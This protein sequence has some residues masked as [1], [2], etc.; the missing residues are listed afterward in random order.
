MIQIPVDIIMKFTRRS[1]TARLSTCGVWWK[2][3]HG[4]LMHLVEQRLISVD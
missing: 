4:F 1:S 2:Y 3:R